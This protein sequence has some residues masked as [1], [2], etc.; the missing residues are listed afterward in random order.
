V[1]FRFGS[2]E[3][4]EQTRELRKDGAPVAL[5][6]KPFELLTLLLRERSR[7]V[8]T[9]EL[10][11]ALWP[12]VVVS[13]SSLT[14]AVSHARRALDDT[15]QGNLVKSFPRRGYRFC[16][17]VVVFETGAHAEPAPPA[18]GESD[19]GLPF[20][21]R[22]RALETLRA[23][24]DRALAGSES[25][26]LV[27]GIPGVG[28]SRLVEVFTREVARRGPLV[29]TGRCREG[30]G[31]P[32]LWPWVQ[33]VRGLLAEPSI[34][35]EVR[36]LVAATDELAGLVQE[37]EARPLDAGAPD[38]SP[39]QRRFH[40]F[41]AIERAL[42]LASRRR[43]LVVVLED[44]HWAGPPSLRVLEHL[45][46]ETEPHPILIVG[47]VREE[48]R[49]RGDP[50]QRTLSILRRQDRTAR[51]SLSGL[52]RG[53]VGGLLERKLGRPAPS[54]LISELAAR[55][56]GVPLYLREAIRLLEERGDLEHP[57]R[58]ARTGM[59]LPVHSLGLIRRALEGLSEPCHDLVAAAAVI[60]REF[61]MPFVSAVA[62]IPRDEALDL[63]DEASRAGV[64]EA[65]PEA[66]AT[67]RFSH[68]LYQEAAYE[69]LPPSLRVRLHYRTA[70][71][72][73]RQHGEHLDPVAAELAH[74]RHQ[75]LALSDPESAYACAHR[76]AEKAVEVCAYEHAA[77]H[78]EQARA[79]LEHCDV[80]VPERQ[81]ETLLALGEAWRL[82]GD[83]QR[84]REVFGSA[85]EAARALDRP[86]DFARAAVGLCNLSSWATEDE[87][88]RACLKEALA[89]LDDEPCIE[90][91]RLLSR[92]AY[93]D[94]RVSRELSEPVARRAVALAR[95]VGD[96]EALQE[97]LYTLHFAIAGPDDLDERAELTDELVA[98]TPS[99]PSRDTAVIALLDVASDRIALGDAKGAR[100]YR[101]RAAQVVGDGAY[102]GLLWHL[103]VFDA[104]YALLEGRFEVTERLAG[105]AILLGLRS[106]PP[107]ARG[108]ETAHRALLHR[109]RD[110]HESVIELLSPLSTL[111]QGAIHWV[112]AV[113]ARSHLAAG[114]EATACNLFE[115]L[116]EDD[117]AVVP[118][119]IRWT[120]TLVEAAHLCSE[121]DDARRARLL[122]GAL[123]P[124]EHHH[125]VLPVPICYGGPVSFGLARLCDTLG[126]PEEAAELYTEAS[127]ACVLVGAR[128]MQARVALEHGKLLARRG[129][130]RAAH[131]LVEGSAA[132]AGEL[133]MPGVA[134][135][136]RAQLDRIR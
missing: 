32:P 14:R 59:S 108:V 113:L 123:S 63:L 129:Q 102:P 47:T 119:N 19:G 99:A 72:L 28:K 103:S 136:A 78:Y 111:Q 65:V 21:G 1:I 70:E 104:G 81:L 49:E 15:H 94:I 50:L 85:M 6:P 125:G 101:N 64:V 124:V 61:R 55:T 130:K 126:R 87:R 93:F 82:A 118:R 73:E 23:V 76:A 67:W 17:E 114:D 132:L 117:F 80:V 66:P 106:A 91:V 127:E 54:D 33:V 75:S 18:N 7:V 31:V 41:D 79:A 69:A 77:T 84:R 37:R 45:A 24:L 133:R 34:A 30:E 86:R 10:F 8:P 3:L 29:L 83:A 48:A 95:S 43:P 68:A 96:P 92:Q 13:P 62:E 46:F 5:Q 40:S 16:G 121:L 56:E 39:E 42:Q 26:A 38:V 112:Q 122:H 4:D 51:V 110:E 71:R 98:V 88:A 35:P 109:E 25:L 135:A 60:G 58:I 2:F 134:A 100:E 105:E 115:R 52:T 74:H 116:A 27:S 90:R 120:D 9:D 89:G 107:D 36:E 44:L 12:G 97:A 57:E 22:E 53:E 11:E 20:V 131:G 128:P